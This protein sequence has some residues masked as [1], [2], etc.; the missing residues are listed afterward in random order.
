MSVSGISAG[1]EVAL[2]LCVLG[3]IAC[4]VG[5]VDIWDSVTHPQSPPWWR[6]AGLAPQTGDLVVNQPTRLGFRA[7]AE[8]TR[9]VFRAA[10]PGVELSNEGHTGSIRSKVC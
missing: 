2:G 6:C 10:E 1:Y 8:Q 4:A 7:R 3:E 9:Q 5:H